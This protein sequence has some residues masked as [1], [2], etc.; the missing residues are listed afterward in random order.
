MGAEAFLLLWV[1]SQHFWVVQWSS[2][3]FRFKFLAVLKGSCNLNKSTPLVEY[4]YYTEN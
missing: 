4:D 1:A 2:I 3:N